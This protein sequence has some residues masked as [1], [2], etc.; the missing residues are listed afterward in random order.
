MEWYHADTSVR[1]FRA[2]LLIVTLEDTPFLSAGTGTQ[3]CLPRS[4]TKGDHDFLEVIM[5]STSYGVAH[6][7]LQGK[8]GFLLLHNI[9]VRVHVNFTR[10]NK[11]EAM[12]GR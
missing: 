11:I 6:P 7:F 4:H 9:H 3:T 8:A 1:K 2:F 5:G 10:V 12:Y